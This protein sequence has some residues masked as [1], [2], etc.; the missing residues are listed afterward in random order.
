MAEMQIKK[1]TIRNV[2]IGII[3]I[4]VLFYFFGNN[5]SS[6][7]DIVLSGQ[8]G[9]KVGD[10][11]PDFSITDVDGD[12]ISLSQFKGKPVAIA[13]FATW[14]TPCQIEADRLKQ[15]DDETGRNKFI[16]YQ[17]GVDNKESLDD[18]K[19]FKSGYGNSDWVVGFGFDTAEQYNVRTLD[20][21]LILDKEGN[22]VYRDNGIPASLDELRKYLI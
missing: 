20:T 4:G 6:S 5:R 12:Q 19:N 18:L 10:I 9:S 2:I 11:A 13:F 22:I 8:I 14:C 1:K 15:L 16:V 3:I 21:T 7:G 17:I